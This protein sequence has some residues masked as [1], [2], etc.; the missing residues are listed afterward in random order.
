MPPASGRAGLCAKHPA[1]AGQ[2]CAEGGRPPFRRLR[3]L[4]DRALVEWQTPQDAEAGPAA[5]QCTRDAGARAGQDGQACLGR[6]AAST[7]RRERSPARAPKR[8]LEG[9]EA[10][11]AVPDPKRRRAQ[12]ASSSS[13]PELEREI[14]AFRASLVQGP[15]F[16]KRCLL[17]VHCALR[18]LAQEGQG[19]MDTLGLRNVIP[20]STAS[21]ASLVLGCVAWLEQSQGLPQSQGRLIFAPAC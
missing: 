5:R 19:G 11:D 9:P 20:D 1:P 10:G 4:G 21:G 6:C 7:R 18:W 15:K 14:E 12:D 16:V 8:S 17:D 13:R 2:P 3:R